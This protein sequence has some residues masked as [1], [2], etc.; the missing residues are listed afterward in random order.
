MLRVYLK[1]SMVV[2]FLF[3]YKNYV[4][5]WLKI[6]VI[7]CKVNDVYMM[8]ILFFMNIKRVNEEE[9]IFGYLMKGKFRFLEI[10][11]F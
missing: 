5:D 6:V 10:Y 7:G 8:K 2:F 9:N 4:R 1:K 3:F 11:I